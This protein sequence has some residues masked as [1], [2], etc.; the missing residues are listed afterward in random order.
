MQ[1][2]KEAKA[3]LCVGLELWSSMLEGKLEQSG[4]LHISFA[5]V[6]CLAQCD[7]KDAVA[8]LAR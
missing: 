1:T 5:Y 6:R 4:L 7:G 2:A 3:I 8:S